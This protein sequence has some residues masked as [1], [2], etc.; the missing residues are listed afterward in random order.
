MAEYL[1]G[2]DIGTSACKT[3]VFDKAGTVIASAVSSY[4]IYYPQNGH[5]E[6][7]PEE[8]LE[9]V[10]SSVK[11]IFASGK[12]EPRDIISVGI[13]GQSWSAVCIDKSGRILFDNP[14]WMDVR[15]AEI[16]KNTPFAKDIFELCGNP[17]TANYTTPKI[18]W[19]KQ[20]YPDVFKQIY[21]V[22]QSNSYIIY[23][24]TGTLSQDLS[25][26]YGWHFWDM[27]SSAPNQAMA[28]SLGIDLSLLPDVYKSHEI[29]GGISREASV[30]SGL[31]EGTPVVAGGVDSACGTLGAGVI[32][33]GETQEAGGQ[34]G[35]MSICC[36][37]YKTHEKLILCN[38]AVPG[39]Y[40][41]QGGTV[42]G[43]ASLKWLRENFFA[44]LSFSEMDKLAQKIGPGSDGVIF[45]P[46]MSGER[47]PIWDPGAKGVFYGLDF[48]KNRAHFIRAVMEGVAYSLVHNLKTAEESGVYI[49]KLYATGG[50]ANSSLWTQIKSDAANTPAAVPLSD[51]STNLGAAILGGVAVGLYKDFKE[52][53]TSTVKIKNTYE[54]SAQNHKIYAEN[55]NVY[56]ELYERLKPIT[57]S[58]K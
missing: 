47:S 37:C 20:N 30:L 24:L 39:K 51:N 2:I 19:F 33:D 10:Y 58:I 34:S 43:G 52:A 21:K 6:Q 57:D 8:W 22:L 32:D 12:A 28:Q 44:G 14:I 11:T 36:D 13:D 17:F 25:Q 50:S 45:L 15:S 27:R 41:L 18:I 31:T 54:P 16:C 3:A 46:Y 55:Y 35:G 56:R 26:C 29:V 5:V 1:L 40:L 7:K 38:H 23:K 4:N 53:V 48:S 42:G 9:A 49:R